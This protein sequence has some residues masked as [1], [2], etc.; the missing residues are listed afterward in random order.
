M[1]ILKC[2]KPIKAWWIKFTYTD[3]FK[4]I[5]VAALLLVSGPAFNLIIKTYIGIGLV[6]DVNAWIGYFGNLLGAAITII[7]LSFTLWQ[8]SLYHKK[9]NENHE[10]LKQLQITT[11]IHAKKQ[12]RLRGVIEELKTL[13]ISVNPQRIHTTRSIASQNDETNN[14][15]ILNEITN[16]LNNISLNK[17][18]LEIISEINKDIIDLSIINKNLEAYLTVYADKMGE[19]IHLYSNN[20]G[21]IK[22]KDIY[23]FID[24]LLINP[25]YLQFKSSFNDVIISAQEKIDSNL[26]ANHGVY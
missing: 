10:E 12:E 7:V 6:G 4:Y 17:E 25:S 13:Y 3:L 20:K 24:T 21:D 18:L 9:Q 5:L 14:M 8:N 1:T 26:N 22:G 23:D 19:I 15:R 11:A 2:F 16:L